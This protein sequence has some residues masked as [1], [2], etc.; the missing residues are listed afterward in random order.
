MILPIQQYD[1]SIILQ[2]V[3]D[4]SVILLRISG[5]EPL[6]KNKIG[7][8][9]YTIMSQLTIGGENLHQIRNKTSYD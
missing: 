7:F 1:L 3:K 8:Y 9:F 4:I 2:S 6:L 5:D